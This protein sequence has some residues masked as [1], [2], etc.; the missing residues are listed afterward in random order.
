MLQQSLNASKDIRNILKAVIG[1]C[2]QS[3][4]EK[5][6]TLLRLRVN[7]RAASFNESMRHESTSCQK[8]TGFVHLSLVAGPKP[9]SGP[10]KRRPKGGQTWQEI[11]LRLSKAKDRRVVIPT[12]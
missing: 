8:F 5:P 2:K 4:G 11:L 3:E 6:A 10:H 1:S 9:N 7:Q 12:C